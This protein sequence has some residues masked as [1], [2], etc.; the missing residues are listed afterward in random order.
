MDNFARPFWR[1]AW[2]EPDGT[3][4][5]SRLLTTAVVLTTLGV[6]VYVTRLSHA[7]PDL[8]IVGGF[9]S[10]VVLALYGVNK[11]GSVFTQI[12]GKKSED[13]SSAT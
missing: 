4:S 5:S 12:F 6:V 10:T 7:L 1:N 9:L 13:D 11:F 3:P 8:K 2:R